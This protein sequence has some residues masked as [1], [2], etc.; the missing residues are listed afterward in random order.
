MQKPAVKYT[1]RGLGGG[2]TRLAPQIDLMAKRARSQISSRTIRK[3]SKKTK[4]PRW[5]KSI[6]RRITPAIQNH[7]GRQAGAAKTPIPGVRHEWVNARNAVGENIREIVPCPQTPQHTSSRPAAI[8]N[9]ADQSQD[10]KRLSNT[11]AQILGLFA[12]EGVSRAV[13]NPESLR[14]GCGLGEEEFLAALSGVL[15]DFVEAMKPRDALEKLALE[16]LMVQH[17][18]VLA[19]S[20]QASVS[21]DL[22]IVKVLNAAC[23]GASSSF[24]RL[25]TSFRDHRRPKDFGASFTIGQANVA[26]QQVIQTVQNRELSG[27]KYDEQRK[28]GQSGPAPRTAALLPN[29]QRPAVS[30]I[31]HQENAAMEAVNRPPNGSGKGARKPQCAKARRAVSRK[32]R[33]PKADKADYQSP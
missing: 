2:R 7:P 27:G 21:T 9:P 16:Q 4:P 30:A 19:L 22:D 18:R 24:R 23:D 13:V 3:R 33:I 11:H 5:A 20:R 29:A 10:L 8:F 12:Y 17:A 32:N 6:A 31:N 26:Q 28:M 15:P 25:M 1:K 14:A